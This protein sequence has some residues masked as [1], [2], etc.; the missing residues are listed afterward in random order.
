MD[1]RDYE[2]DNARRSR[3]GGNAARRNRPNSRNPRPES[4]SSNNPRQRT[5]SSQRG[6]GYRGAAMSSRRSG[7]NA[8]HKRSNSHV[9]RQRPRSSAQ[10]RSNRY[11]YSAQAQKRNSSRLPVIIIAGAVILVL[12]LVFLIRGCAGC[13]NSDQ[14]QEG[15]QQSQQSQQTPAASL[16][17]G[18]IVMTLDGDENTIVKQ[19]ESYIEPGCHALDKQE[20]NITQNIKTSGDVD[21]SKVGD[22]TVTYTVRNAANMEASTTRTVHVV[23]N[24][25]VDTD[26]ISVMMYHYVYTE[27]NPP[28]EQDTNYLLDTKLEAQL[29]W[30]TENDYYFPSYE[31]LRAYIDGKHSLP[32]KSVVLT[33]DDAEDG[34]L[35]YGIPL[36]EKYKVPATSFIIC[37]RPESAQKL[38]DHASPYIT[39]QSHS[40]SLHEDGATNIG[41]G[42][43]IYDL[44]EEEL[45]EDCQKATDMLGTN[46]AFAYPFGD[47]SDAAP[48][49]LERAGY[50]CAFTI[51]NGQVKPGDDPYRLVRMRVLAESPLEGFVYEVEHGL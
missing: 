19:G 10:R 8:G 48:R 21:T 30:L 20:G 3:N 49:A 14:K 24:M 23:D 2:R 27:A 25:D 43:H 6:A 46:E 47:V 16:E 31:E 29:K 36:L 51:V 34:F 18:R 44:N 11:A 38:I 42:G 39:F 28:E 26:G 35:N 13:S 17:P 15:S 12:A 7:S 4:R 1:Y 9:Q 33:F 37:G 32:K 50:L 5:T 22:Y 40:W 41:R 45:V